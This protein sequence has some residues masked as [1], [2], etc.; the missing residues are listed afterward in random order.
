MRWKSWHLA[1]VILASLVLLVCIG[2][3]I[4]IAIEPSYSY[5]EGVYFCTLLTSS[6]GFPSEIVIDKTASK[7]FVMIYSAFSVF[8][9]FF[10]LAA[11]GDS[12]FKLQNVSI[13]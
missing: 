12:I 10:S 7:Y 2:G 8:A 4:F 6:C 13:N 9:F 3:A 5:L 1:L 11:L